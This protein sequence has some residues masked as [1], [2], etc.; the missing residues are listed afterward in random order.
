MVYKGFLINNNNLSVHFFSSWWNCHSPQASFDYGLYYYDEPFLCYWIWLY[1]CW[2]CCDFVLVQR[3]GSHWAAVFQPTADTHCLYSRSV[4]HYTRHLWKQ[5]RHCLSD[6]DL[7]V[8]QNTEGR[9]QS[10]VMDNDEL[11]SKFHTFRP[12]TRHSYRP[13][14]YS[15]SCAG[16]SMHRVE[17]A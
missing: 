15:D 7:L 11:I 16:I 9:I 10:W 4:I 2:C 1:H 6:K 14:C 5:R 12:Q 13:K 8:W 3:S 17:F